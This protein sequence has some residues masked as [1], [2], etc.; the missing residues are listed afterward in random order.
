M[1]EDLYLNSIQLTYGGI[2]KTATSYQSNWSAG[3][4]VAPATA[5]VDRLQQRYLETYEY[6]SNSG[7]STNGCETFENFIKSGMINHF[8]CSRD[9]NNRATEVQL[10]TNYSVAVNPLNCKMF[11][12]AWYRNTVSYTT[13][14][15]SIV[16]TQI[17]S[18]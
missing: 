11:V 3:T 1:D 6:L 5:G 2:T 12:V 7:L 9:S 17:S 4:N 18:V 13:S 10:Q 15:G 8:D 16:S 14:Q